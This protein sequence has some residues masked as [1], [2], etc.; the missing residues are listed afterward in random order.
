[1]DGWGWMVVVVSELRPDGSLI[2]VEY[3]SCVFTI[4]VD[5]CE[6]REICRSLNCECLRIE[7][8]VWKALRGGTNAYA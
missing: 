2:S 8:L 1:M 7:R 6:S 5:G 4:F 3:V